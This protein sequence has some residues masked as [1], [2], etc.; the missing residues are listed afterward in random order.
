MNFQGIPSATSALNWIIISLQEKSTALI[1]E[2]KE[3]KSKHK[4]R[5]TT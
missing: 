5:G 4:N 3:I 1:K 2:I